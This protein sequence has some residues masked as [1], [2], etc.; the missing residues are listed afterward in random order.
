MLQKEP[1]AFAIIPITIGVMVDRALTLVLR[2]LAPC[3]ITALLPALGSTFYLAN[4]QQRILKEIATHTSA[5]AATVARLA[6]INGGEWFAICILAVIGIILLQTLSA[7]LTLILFN[8]YF[9]RRVDLKEQIAASLFRSHQL[10]VPM[11]AL[12]LAAATFFGIFVTVLVLASIFFIIAHLP[13]LLAIFA[14]IIIIPTYF[15][16]IPMFGSLYAFAWM[17]VCIEGTKTGTTLQR[18][19]KLIT[20]PQTRL[21]ALKM[22]WATFGLSLAF[23]VFLG[24]AA[25][26]FSI[27]HSI[28]LTGIAL[29]MG[30]AVFIPFTSAL[31]VIFF[32]DIKLREG[33]LADVLAQADVVSR[34]VPAA[35]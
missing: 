24:M 19:I 13:V 3:M 1:E 20:A 4:T 9:G 7:T 2:N 12:G 10:L 29:G 22:G 31:S 23:M 6:A 33:S 14:I 18:S 26:A 35:T 28:I 11:L 27:F 15:V 30:Y 34:V 5:G 16:V 21:R 25:T 17:E 32:T 8:A